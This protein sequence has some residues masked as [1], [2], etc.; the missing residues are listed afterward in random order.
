[1]HAPCKESANKYAIEVRPRAGTWSPFFAA[2]P[3]AEKDLVALVLAHG[4]RGTVP[5][6]SNLQMCGKGVTNDGEWWASFAQNEGT[7]TQS[8]FLLCKNLPSKLVFGV[9]QG[10]PQYRVI[11]I[12]QY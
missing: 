3:V 9:N 6:G 7:P 8:Y 11:G 1:M 10:F 12:P 4:P 2:V 5:S